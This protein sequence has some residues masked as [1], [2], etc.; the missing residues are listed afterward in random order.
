MVPTDTTLAVVQHELQLAQAWAARHAWDLA[1]NTD[2]LV[3]NCSTVHP[4]DGKPVRLRADL[5]GYRAVPPAWQCVDSEGAH[6]KSAYPTPGTLPDGKSSLFHSQPVI[7]A[8]FNRLAFADG[9]G[10]HQGD[11]GPATRWLTVTGDFAKPT[12]LAEM[13]QVL[14]V[15]L[16]FSPGWMS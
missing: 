14:D 6:A 9:N 2:T 13:L 4:V 15:H 3:L 16:R 7:C 12:T 8:P 1:L 10:P 5:V 11:W